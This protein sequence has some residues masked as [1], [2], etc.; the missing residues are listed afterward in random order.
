ML[1][2]TTPS[3]ASN[4]AARRDGRNSLGA[5]VA[6]SCSGLIV[7]RVLRQETTP[8]TFPETLPHE[9]GA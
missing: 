6:A 2:A 4:A 9:E 8:V 7:K 3:A 5:A 1:S